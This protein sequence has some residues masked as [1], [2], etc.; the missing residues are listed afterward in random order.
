LRRQRRVQQLMMQMS[1]R[2]P[3]AEQTPMTISLWSSIQER[4][5]P[6]AV[7]PWQTPWFVLARVERDHTKGDTTYVLAVPA[8]TA[9]RTIEEVLLQTKADVRSELRTCAADHATLAVARASV[10]ALGVAAHSRLALHVATSALTGS[11]LQALATAVAIWLGFVTRTATGVSRTDF[12]RVAVTSASPADGALR[13]E[14]AVIAAVF[15]SVIADGAVLVLA[16][17]G[18][19]ARVVSAAFGA[20]AI[21]V[22]AGLDD[23]IAALLACNG[24]DVPIVREA[25]GV[26]VAT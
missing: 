3:T 20:T 5:W 14:L 7:L 2:A 15:V 8:T 13:L 9:L 12:L 26:D 6:P 16:R 24:R 10:V 17:F 21:T 4:I 23:T 18:V 19:A 22:F 1:R 11:A 25:V